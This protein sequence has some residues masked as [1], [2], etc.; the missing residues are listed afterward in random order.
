MKNV[1]IHDAKTNLSK[2][3][4]AAKRG[5]RIQIGR[6]GKAEVALT[7]LSPSIAPTKRLFGAAKANITAQKD[8]F[9]PATDA[10]VANL[11]LGGR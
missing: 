7:P 8:A 5:E 2:Y 10:L 6:F 4:K 1:P 9:S 11:L 3:I